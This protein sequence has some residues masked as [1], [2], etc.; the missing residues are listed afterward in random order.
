MGVPIPK[1]GLLGERPAVSG[2]EGRKRNEKNCKVESNT[3]E[4][5]V[6]KTR[7]VLLAPNLENGSDHLTAGVCTFRGGP[8]YCIPSC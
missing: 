2:E 1:V 5:P 7:R 8:A 3:A 6:M 4:G